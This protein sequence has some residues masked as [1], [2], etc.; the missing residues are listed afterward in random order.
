M[1]SILLT[2]AATV[3]L[4]VGGLAVPDTADARPPRYRGWT[5][6]YQVRPYYY[7]YRAPALLLSWASGLRRAASGLLLLVLSPV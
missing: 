2:L 1:K 5:A 6:G 3:A 7:R 4:L